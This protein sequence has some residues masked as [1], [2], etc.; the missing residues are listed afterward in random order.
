[1]LLKASWDADHFCFLLSLLSHQVCSLLFH[2][3][4]PQP[5]ASLKVTGPTT[6]RLKLSAEINLPFTQVE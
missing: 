2:T 4:L 5:T 3:V 6:H 1:M